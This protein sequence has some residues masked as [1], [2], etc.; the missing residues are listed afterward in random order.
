MYNLFSSVNFS[1]AI[2]NETQSKVLTLG[3]VR[4][5]GRG[6]SEIV[7]QEEKKCYQKTIKVGTLKGSV[8]VENHNC[9][10]MLSL[11]VYDKKPVYFLTNCMQEIKQI[12]K[13]KKVYNKTK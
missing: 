11:F 3:I 7:Y 6:V 2:K 8:L 9:K 1:N 10:T 5:S 4:K 13:K 12:N